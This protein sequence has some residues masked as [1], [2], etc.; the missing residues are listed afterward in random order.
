MDGR[1]QFD[2][3]D[4]DLEAVFAHLD[5]FLEVPAGLGLCLQHLVTDDSLGLGLLLIAL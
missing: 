4:Q 5:S 2:D 1:E 3:D